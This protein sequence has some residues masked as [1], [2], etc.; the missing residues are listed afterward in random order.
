MRPNVAPA[1]AA[2]EAAMRFWKTSP[3]HERALQSPST[4]IGVGVASWKYG[5]QWVLSGY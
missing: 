5:N 2:M 4:E 1:G 3:E